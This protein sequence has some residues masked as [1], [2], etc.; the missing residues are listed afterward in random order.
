M[1]KLWIEALYQV[2]DLTSNP[3]VFLEPKKCETHFSKSKSI[4]KVLYDATKLIE[5]ECNTGKG[6]NA[7]KYIGV[8]HTY[9]EDEDTC[10]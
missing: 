1:D 3:E 5:N 10:N 6:N 2:K 4:T 7:G 8:I 9:L